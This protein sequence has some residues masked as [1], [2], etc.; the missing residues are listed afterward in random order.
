MKFMKIYAALISSFIRMKQTFSQLRQR[1]QKLGLKALK[2]LK[3]TPWASAPPVVY[4]WPQ[5]P[6]LAC[7]IN[8][9]PFDYCKT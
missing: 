2:I 4:F 5:S 9:L 8:Y 7:F 3:K 6:S 1:D